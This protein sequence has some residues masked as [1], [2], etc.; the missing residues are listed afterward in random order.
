MSLER[1]V[2]HHDPALAEQRCA[3]RPD[4]RGGDIAR[5]TPHVDAGGG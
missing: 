4:V 2:E 1:A 5:M 3:W